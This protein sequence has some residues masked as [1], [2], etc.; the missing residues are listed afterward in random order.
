[1]PGIEI[2][3]IFDYGIFL[4]VAF[5]SLVG[6]SGGGLLGTYFLVFV[7]LHFSTVLK[8]SFMRELGQQ[9]FDPIVLE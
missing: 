2:T 9:N 1:V 6:A 7:V 5:V 8:I 4:V 3:Y